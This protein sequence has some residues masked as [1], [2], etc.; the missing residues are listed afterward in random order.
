MICEVIDQM[1]RSLTNVGCIGIVCFALPLF[2]VCPTFSLA[3]ILH[4]FLNGW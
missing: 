3:E 4:Q 2:H 1:S